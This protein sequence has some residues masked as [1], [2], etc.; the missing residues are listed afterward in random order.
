MNHNLVIGLA[1]FAVGGGLLFLGLPKN[2]VSP[3]FLQFEAAMILYTPII[4][5]FLAAGAAEIITALLS[6]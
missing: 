5:V 3:R 4:L 2:G 6:H 1:L